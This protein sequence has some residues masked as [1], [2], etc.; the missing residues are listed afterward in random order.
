VAA[1]RSRGILAA[2][3]QVR[4]VLAMC[5]FT[6]SRLLASARTRTYA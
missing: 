4:G 2:R 3:K 5:T 1:W 6:I